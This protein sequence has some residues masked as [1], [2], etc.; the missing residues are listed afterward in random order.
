[1]KCSSK[2]ASEHSMQCAVIAWAAMQTSVMPGLRW[3]YAIPNGAFFGGEMKTLKGGRKIPMGAIRMAKLKREGLRTGVPDLCL[4]VARGGFHG[5]YIEMKAG[6][7]G[8][9]S[10]DQET[11]LTGL[12]AEGHAAVVCRSAEEAINTLRR[13]LNPPRERGF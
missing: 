2:Q 10:D 12:R 13:Y 5:L 11:W 1:M 3:L 4:P 6:D 7:A 8:T 9:L